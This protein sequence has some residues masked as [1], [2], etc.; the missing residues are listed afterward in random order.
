VL[1][2]SSYADLDS[3]PVNNGV[4]LGGSVYDSSDAFSGSYSFSALPFGSG[5]LAAW[6]SS[7]PPTRSQ[8]YDQ[9]ASQGQNQVSI[10][11]G[12]ELCDITVGGRVAF[13]KVLDIQADSGAG[14]ETDV[15]VWTEVTPTA[16]AS[17]S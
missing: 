12:T 7:T 3:V 4:S 5:T 17:A 8:C 1:I 11:D 16:S 15:T 10:T 9:V 6:T 14:I 2:T 13:L